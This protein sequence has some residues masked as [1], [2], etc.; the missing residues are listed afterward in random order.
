[1]KAARS[2]KHKKHPRVA[3]R[4]LKYL[5]SVAEVAALMGS[6]ARLKI[7]LLLAQA[8]RSVEEIS[9]QTG[10]SIA[11]VSQH[12]KKLRDGGLLDVRRDGV[13]RFYSLGDE[14]TALVLEYLFDIVEISRPALIRD[15]MP[16]GSPGDGAHGDGADGISLDGEQLARAL[17]SRRALILDI[18]EEIETRTTPVESA[19]KIPLA[20]LEA[21]IGELVRSKAYYVL[22][23]GRACD[24][25]GD[26]VRILRENGFKAFRLKESPA[27]IRLGRKA[28][29][30]DENNQAPKGD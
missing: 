20:E 26:G 28:L 11:N 17:A 3:G 19:I 10:E 7:L 29:D 12:L 27:G 16:L 18:R 14:R 4:G 22:C 25:A 13:S 9:R 2:S 15:P 1:M 8:P 5:E 23:R 30:E 6:E 24:R 21:R